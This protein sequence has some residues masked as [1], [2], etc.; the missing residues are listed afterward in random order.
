MPL[1]HL[2]WWLKSVALASPLTYVVELLHLGVTGR[3]EFASPVVLLLAVLLFLL[4]SWLLAEALFR[5]RA[6]A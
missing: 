6:Y 2:P 5:R 3:S 1:S 4:T